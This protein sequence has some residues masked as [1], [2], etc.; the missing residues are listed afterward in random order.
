MFA[1]CGLP[2]MLS[3][4]APTSRRASVASSIS[5]SSSALAAVEPLEL[6]LHDLPGLRRRRDLVETGEAEGIEPGGARGSV[7]VVHRA[8]RS[9]LARDRIARE[10][11]PEAAVLADPGRRLVDQVRRPGVGAAGPDLDAVAAGEVD[12]GDP[13]RPARVVA[14]PEP[15]APELRQRHGQPANAAAAPGWGSPPGTRPGGS[16]RRASPRR[17]RRPGVRRR[18]RDRLRSSKRRRRSAP[19][20]SWEA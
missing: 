3:S 9:V 1:R 17:R 14:L 12:E 18:A 16:T 19:W 5:R 15:L 10:E 4:R 7:A 20:K 8:G 6:G 2:R 11:A 13:E